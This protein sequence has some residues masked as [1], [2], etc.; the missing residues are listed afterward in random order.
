MAVS[1][2]ILYVNITDTIPG[3]GDIPHGGMYEV[4]WEDQTYEQLPMML[5]AFPEY[6]QMQMEDGWIYFIASNPI[7]EIYGST[8]IR[9]SVEDYQ[10]EKISDEGIETFFVHGDTAFCM[11]DGQAVKYSISQ[12]TEKLRQVNQWF[13]ED[14]EGMY[15]DYLEKVLVPKFGV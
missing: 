12:Q 2:G 5:P 8:L 13:E 1:D 11:K 15:Q 6:D 3:D 14:P 4:N 10:I 9:M 7:N